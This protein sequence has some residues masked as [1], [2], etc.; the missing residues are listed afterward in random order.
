MHMHVTVCLC[1]LFCKCVYVLYSISSKYAC[2][3]A[4]VVMK[5]R[6]MHYTCAVRATSDSPIPLDG[7]A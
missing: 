4:H 1:V 2:S 6:D 5:S 3:L 7:L